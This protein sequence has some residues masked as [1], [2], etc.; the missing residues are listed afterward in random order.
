MKETMG[1]YNQG[2]MVT[3]EKETFKSLNLNVLKGLN[4]HADG[5]D[6]ETWGSAP[7]NRKLETRLAFP[8]WRTGEEELA[9]GDRAVST[10]RKSVWYKEGLTGSI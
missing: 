10:H 1:G 4:G 6:W 9:G 8:G 2:A 7:G 5:G 3:E